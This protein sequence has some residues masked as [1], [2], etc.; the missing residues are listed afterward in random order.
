M[1][2]CRNDDE[3]IAENRNRC[4]ENSQAEEKKSNKCEEQN[5][6]KSTIMYCCLNKQSFQVYETI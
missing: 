4:A 6:R 5:R 2:I 3:I 1:K